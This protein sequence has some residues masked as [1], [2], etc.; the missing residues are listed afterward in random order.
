MPLTDRELIEKYKIKPTD[1]ILDV[2]GSMKQHWDLPIDTLVDLIRPE[3]APYGKS[4]LLAKHFIRLDVTKEKLPFRDK[5]FDFVLCTHTLEDLYNPFL[6]IDEMSRVGKR[7]Y[8]ATPSFG[9]DITYSHYNLTD[10]LTGGRR[11]P[12]HA[13]HK[14][15]FYIKKGQIQILP[16][17]YSLL[18]T[19][20]FQVVNW[21]GRDELQYYWENSINYSEIKDLSIHKLINLY[22]EWIKRNN[23]RIT[24]G[25]T[26]VVID[27]PYFYLKEWVKLIL[28][29]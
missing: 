23:D 5:E 15:L 8:I 29:K 9:S 18:A 14:W 28:S 26:L 27:N 21:K 20:E 11:V 19:T 10:W 16:K 13:H 1:K 12:G 7:G 3:E 2:G 25:R 22:R 17:N 24:K 6:I 4:K